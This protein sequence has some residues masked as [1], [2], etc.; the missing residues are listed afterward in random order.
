MNKR[1][2]LELLCWASTI[3]AS[4]VPSPLGLAIVLSSGEVRG[5]YFM[6][7][8]RCLTSSCSSWSGLSDRGGGV[9]DFTVDQAAQGFYNSPAL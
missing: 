4:T 9:P 3:L 2:N 8:R 5:L 6:I 7:E 1:L